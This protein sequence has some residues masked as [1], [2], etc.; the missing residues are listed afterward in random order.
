MI[1]VRKLFSLKDGTRERKIIRILM[2]WET[3][4]K[5]GNSPDILY[6]KDFLKS[7]EGERALKD[8]M[9]PVPE[10]RSL[11]DHQADPERLLILLNRIR[12]LFLSY[13][14]IAPA[15]WDLLNPEDG[16]SGGGQTFPAV[17]YLDEL[18]S[19]FNVGS[20]FRT[21]ECFGVSRIYLSPGTA[22]PQHPRAQRTAMGCTQRIPWERLDYTGL[23][24]L[25]KTV[26]A[27]EL[28]GEGTADFAFPSE[29]ILVLGS[30]E[31]GV[32]PEC[33]TLAKQSGGIVTID[34]YGSKA[35]LNVSVAFG[36]VMNAW[37]ASLS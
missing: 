28:G 20:V 2:D 29:G 36:I 8:G 16:H 6:L 12:H 1:T 23:A 5:K 33:L 27:M 25:N 11:L 7:L 30:E 37:A 34:L 26:F 17:L 9:N 35:S 13:M 32:S 4:L 31:L 3:G 18:R 14:N 22:D 24:E 15:D 21:A 10:L 19:P